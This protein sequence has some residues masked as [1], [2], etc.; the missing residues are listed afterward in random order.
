MKTGSSLL[1]VEAEHCI[2]AV[3]LFPPQTGKNP[4]I[5]STLYWRWYR[6][7]SLLF[8]VVEVQIPTLLCAGQFIRFVKMRA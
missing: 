4:K 7:T 5:S 8:L 6:E 2:Y 3:I 1:H